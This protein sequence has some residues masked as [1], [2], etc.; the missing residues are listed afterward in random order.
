MAKRWLQFLSWDSRGALKL[1]VSGKTYSWNGV[2]TYWGEHIRAQLHTRANQGRVLAALQK[3]YGK[4]QL[5]GGGKD[6]T[7]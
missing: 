6:E 5:E 1:Q 2:S 7:T 4:G 3:Q